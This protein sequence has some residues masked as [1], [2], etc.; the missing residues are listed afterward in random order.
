M[1]QKSSRMSVLVRDKCD[2]QNYQAGIQVKQTDCSI[3]IRAPLHAEITQRVRR[4]D[5]QKA[6]HT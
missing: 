6:R 2:A 1:D 3:G 5:K 4:M